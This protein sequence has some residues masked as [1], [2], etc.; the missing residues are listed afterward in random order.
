MFNRLALCLLLLFLAFH[1]A[2]SK[3]DDGS[4]DQEIVRQ[5]ASN[6]NTLIEGGKLERRNL[7]INVRKGNVTVTGRIEDAQESRLIL[8]SVITA[9]NVAG[10][11]LNLGIGCEPASA[12]RRTLDSQ[13]G[14]SPLRWDDGDW[15]L[16]FGT[17]PIRDRT[18][19]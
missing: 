18:N 12:V 9:S 6:L 14:R 5:I 13:R 1:P 15:Q 8:D 7:T 19:P 10:L 11:E 3:A 17:E 4:K 2:N 16:D